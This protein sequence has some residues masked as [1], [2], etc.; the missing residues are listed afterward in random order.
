M[1]PYRVIGRGEPRTESIEDGIDFVC[2]HLAGHELVKRG[3]GRRHV[4]VVLVGNNQQQFRF[5][6]DP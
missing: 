2:I 1:H 3:F 4:G 5:A 6:A